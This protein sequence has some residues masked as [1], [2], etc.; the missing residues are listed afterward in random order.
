MA[1]MLIGS[2]PYNDRDKRNL[3]ILIQKLRQQLETLSQSTGKHYEVSM[4]VGGAWFHAVLFYPPEL[5]DVLDFAFIMNYDDILRP[6]HSTF[7]SMMEGLNIYH[8]SYGWPYEKMVMGVPFYGLDQRN[9]IAPTYKDY[10]DIAEE[11]GAEIAYY[12]D[13][14]ETFYYNGMP[15]ITK[16]MHFFMKR[17][18]LGMGMWH[19]AADLLQDEYSLLRGMRD[20]LDTHYCKSITVTHKPQLTNAMSIYPNPCKDNLYVEGINQ[21]KGL[22]SR[23]RVL[24]VS[25]KVMFED[26]FHLPTVNVNYLPKGIYILQALDGHKEVIATQRFV[27]N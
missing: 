3:I 9:I 12:K 14:F 25:G 17:G 24:D 10:K 27:K 7:I 20:S 4:A 6:H 22:F 18:G 1:L 8:D 19:I 16:K 23:I 26:D 13:Q 21:S 5:I 15:T 11:L 2:S